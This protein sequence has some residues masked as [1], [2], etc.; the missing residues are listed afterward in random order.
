VSLRLVILI[1]IVFVLPVSVVGSPISV[2]SINYFNQKARQMADSANFVEAEQYYQKTIHFCDSTKNWELSLKNKNSLVEIW[3]IQ[4]AYYKAD[5]L[6][7]VLSLI[8]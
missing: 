5:S 8:N 3:I 2:D 6:L 1:L 7:N 4:A